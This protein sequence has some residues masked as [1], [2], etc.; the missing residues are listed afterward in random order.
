MSET[1]AGRDVASPT[2]G[3]YQTNVSADWRDLRDRLYQPTLQPLRPSLWPDA[4]VY[5]RKN[6][7]LRIAVRDQGTEGTCTGQAL[8]ALIDILR[9]HQKSRYKTLA[10]VSARMLYEM[11]RVQ[12]DGRRNATDGVDSLRAIIKGFYHYGVCIDGGVR[13]PTGYPRKSGR[14]DDAT[15]PET[16]RGYALTIHRAKAA[17]EISLGA[18]F[19]VRPSLNDYHA[20]LNEVG[21]L[22]VAANVHS[23]WD[24]DAV[25][26]KEGVIEPA[27]DS[28]GAHAF[29]IVGYTEEGFLVLNSWGETWGQL[30]LG[31]ANIPGVALWR[32]GDWAN[33]VL[34]C[35]VLR[36]GVSAPKAFDL[37][38]GD[39]GLHFAAGPI[40]TPATPCLDILGHFAHLDDGRFVR[41]G[42]YATD[43]KS[44]RETQA[45]L[46][47]HLKRDQ[48]LRDGRPDAEP[49]PGGRDQWAYRGT[50]IWITGSLE[51]MHESVR[52]AV[53]RKPQIMAR[54]LY[55]FFLFW[56]TD[57]V[58]DT[59]SVLEQL[60]EDAHK[61][62][63]EPGPDL[64]RLIE[65]RVHGLGR[66]FWRDIEKNADNAILPFHDREPKGDAAQ[67]FQLFTELKGQPLHLVAD[68]AGAILLQSYLTR[69]PKGSARRDAFFDA[70]DSLNLI[71]PANRMADMAQGFGDLLDHLGA[72]GPVTADDSGPH[73]R[74]CLHVPTAGF[75]AA[76]CVGVY[77][78]S[79]LHLVSNGFETR[80]PGQH[81]LKSG[82]GV[83][84]PPLLGMSLQS[85]GLSALRSADS[86]RRADTS[87][88]GPK[89]VSPGWSSAFDVLETAP[90]PGLVPPFGHGHMVNHPDVLTRILDRI[91]PKARALS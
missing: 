82:P 76:Q 69:L 56:C 83:Y 66:A 17:R 27:F 22:L 18:Y 86:T 2:I 88:G 3:K 85:S 38:I 70:V 81:D 72:R 31:K 50:L 63:G 53:A 52:L 11:A 24:P 5:D 62:V 16:E 65:E 55:P 23:G 78:R 59:K 25:A 36:M 15:W 75:E 13:T 64:D 37:T 14:D 26:A 34:D 42:S 87:A 48:S 60:F 41:G 10:P 28:R 30:P 21:A 47:A 8:A 84:G 51:G 46:A 67:V 1:R 45:L 73:R 79:M 12:Q 49:P 57:F 7:R 43:P 54:G 90:A 68:G 40:E 29:V 32:Y 20:A 19:R 39:Q 4:R 9:L 77:G 89:S 74:A 6:G 80:H 44:L 61:R 35:W 71:A 33:A 91:A 58:E